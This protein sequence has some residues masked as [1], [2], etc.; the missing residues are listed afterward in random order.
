[1]PDDD[2]E[3]PHNTHSYPCSH[4]THAT[5]S[6]SSSFGFRRAGHS[7]VSGSS[8]RTKLFGAR[9]PRRVGSETSTLESPREGKGWSWSWVGVIG[10]G[11][12]LGRGKGSEGS[13]EVSER[14]VV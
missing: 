6:P 7:S 2:D 13:V 14:E 3:E 10:K 11:K 8:F 5:G 1:M 12:S 4:N 9:T